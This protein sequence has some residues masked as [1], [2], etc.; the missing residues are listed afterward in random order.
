MD[1]AWL[2]LF[3]F[4]DDCYCGILSADS[5]DQNIT[6]SNYQTNLNCPNLLDLDKSKPSLS[7]LILSP[8]PNDGYFSLEIVQESIGSSYQIIDYQGRIIKNGTIMASSQDFDISD[9][10]KC[11]YVI[12]FSQEEDIE[13]FK[14]AV[15]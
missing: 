11:L 4:N 1:Y 8:N 5:L 15:Q 14:F 13:S 6:A 7:S 2:K 9:K 3:L 12:R 10:P